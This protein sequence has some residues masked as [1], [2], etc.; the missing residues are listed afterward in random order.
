M[1]DCWWGTNAS[2]LPD[3]VQVGLRGWQ[4][5]RIA[6]AADRTQDTGPGWSFDYLAHRSHHTGPGE[7]CH[8]LVQ[9]C[10]Q[11][12]ETVAPDIRSSGR[13]ASIVESTSKRPLGADLWLCPAGRVPHGSETALDHLCH[14]PSI[15]FQS[16]Q[17]YPELRQSLQGLDFWL[18]PIGQ[19]AAGQGGDLPL[20]DGADGLDFSGG[21]VVS[22]Y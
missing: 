2:Q 13:K 8:L 5:W 11:R 15:E 16:L 21:E 7:S 9:V 12:G 3:W 10:T 14:R 6:F 22:E 20:D 17:S 19:G 4:E 1:L 18:V